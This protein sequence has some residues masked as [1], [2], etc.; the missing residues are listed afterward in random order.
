MSAQALAYVWDTPNVTPEEKLLLIWLANSC[1]GLGEAVMVDPAGMGT[2]IGAD[3]DRAMTVLAGMEDRGLVRWGAE[4]QASYLWIVYGGDYR[5][6]I[7]WTRETKSRNRRVAALLERDGARCSYCDQTPINYH[8][9]HFIPR[10]KGGH[11]RMNNLVL[12]C[13]DCNLA[14][15]DKMPEVFLIDDPSRFHVLSTNLKYL[16]E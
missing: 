7:D 9:D 11:D 5:D 12:A 2:F 13:P 1:A 10:A 16:H 4:E 14:K 6:P 8:V 3:Y 15:K